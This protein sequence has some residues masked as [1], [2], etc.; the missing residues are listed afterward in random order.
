MQNAPIQI[1]TMRHTDIIKL[2]D[3]LVI[4]RSEVLLL[5][6]SHCSIVDTVHCLTGFIDNLQHK[7]NG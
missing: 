4:V 5:F 1:C 2:V 7:K 6:Q 3:E